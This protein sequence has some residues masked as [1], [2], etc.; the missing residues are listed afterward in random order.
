MKQN[1]L[2]SISRILLALVFI[3]FV[4]QKSVAQTVDG[5]INA[6]EYGNHTDGFNKQGNAYM[7]WDDTN[8]YVGI[9]GSN[10]GESAIIYI[11]KNPLPSIKGGTNADGTLVGQEYDGTNFSALPFRADFVSYFKSGYHEYRTADGSNG[12]SG[13][14]S[15][16][17]SFAASGDSRELSIPW[18][19]MG[20]KPAS[21]AF[22]VYVTSSGG[23]VYNQVP[24]ENASG[25][26]GTSASYSRY[27]IVDNTS[28]GYPFANNPVID[29]VGWTNLQYPQSVTVSK[30]SGAT[31]IFMQV[32]K[33]GVTNY[34]GKGAGIDVCLG[35]NDTDS[36][37]STW[38]EDKWKT[39]TYYKDAGNNDEYSAVVLGD[40]LD[41]GTYYYATRVRYMTNAYQYGGYNTGGGGFWDGATN[42]CGVLT[43]Q[44]YS[45][46]LFS[47]TAPALTSTPSFPTANDAITINFDASLGNILLKDL[48]GHVVYAHTG[49]TTPAGDWQ[50]S[51]TWLQNDAE[52]L[53]TW[54]SGNSYTLSIPNVFTYYGVS[55]T[56]DIRKLSFVMRNATGTLQAKTADN[57][58]F[59]I[60]LYADNQLHVRFNYPTTNLTV[61][62]ND[63][64][65]I[66]AESN[67]A[68]T[69]KL[70]VD[71][72]LANTVAALQMTYT[73]SCG[74]VIGTHEVKIVASKA[75]VSD[76]EETISYYVT[77]STV[78]EALPAGM[79]DGINYVDA[80]TVTLVLYAPQK[81]YIHAIGDFNNWEVDNNYL[82]KRTPDNL[83][84]WITL[85]GL[86]AG[87][88]YG[89]Q[90]LIDGNLRIADPYTDKILDPDNDKNISSSIYP[91]LKLYPTGKTEQI[92]S[93]FQTAK[94]PYAWEIP[95]FSA[96]AQNQLIIYELHIRDFTATGDINGVADKLD[97]LKTL[98]INAIE[99]MPINE[100]EGNDS[101]GYNPSFYFA[102]DK[103]YGTNQAYK[104]FID[105][106]HKKGI[107]VI[108]DIVLNHSF[109]QSPMV[110]MYFDKANDR[111]APE[112]PWFN[113]TA[114]NTL[115][116]WGSDFNH[117]RQ[118][119]K[120]FV[121]RVS[122]YWLTEF[123]I[124]GI[125]FDFTKGFTQTVG[126]GDAYDASRI[127]ILERMYDAIKAVKPNAYVILE[128]LAENSEEI[129][130]ANH[131]IMLWKNMEHAY[132]EALSG[133]NTSGN[134]D[135]SG[136][137]FKNKSF[138]YAN[139]VSYAESHDEE[140]NPYKA[141]TYGNQTQAPVY[142]VKDKATYVNRTAMLEAFNLF[143][144]GPRMLWQFEELAY[145]YSINYNGRVG[146]KPLRWD[147]FDDTDRQGL[148]TK[149]AR[150]I[151]YRKENPT[152]FDWK[153]DYAEDNSCKRIRF[154]DP[155]DGTIKAVV[156]GNFGVATASFE[157]GFGV[158][159][160][161]WFEAVSGTS[162]GPQTIGNA[163]SLAPGEFKV[164]IREDQTINY[165]L[166]PPIG[167]DR[168]IAIN[169]DSPR[170]FNPTDFKFYSVDGKA[171]SAIK[172]KSI[173]G[174][175]TFQYNNA[176]IS[177]DTEILD[178]TK[179]TFTP[180][181][182]ANGSGYASFT[183][184]LEDNTT[185]AP[186]LS[187]KTY[188]TRINV[189][190]VNDAPVITGQQSLFVDKNSPLT[191][192]LNDLTVT[193]PDNAYPV[194]FSLTV[195]D[196][197]NY[198]RVGNTITPALNYAGTLTVTVTVNDGTSDSNTFNVQVKVKQAQTVSFGATSATYG[199]IDFA[200]ATATSGLTVTLSVPVGNT[201]ATIVGNQIHIVGAGT[202]DVT[203]KQTGDNDFSAA[204]E[205]TQT[206][207]VNKAT[208]TITAG[209]QSVPGGTPVE[210]VTGLGSYTATGFVN[211]DN[212]LLVGP[213]TVSYT[214][215]YTT[216]TPEGTSG[217][218]ITPVVTGLIASNYSFI[219]APGTIT[220]IAPLAKKLTLKVY[221]EG[222]WNGTA[223]NM[224]KCQDWV[225]GSETLVD[226]FAGD[227]VDMLSVELHDATTYST[228]AYQLTGLE[229]HQDG[230][231]TSV[232][233]SYIEIPTAATGS[234]FITVKHRNH[235][236]TTSATAVSFSADVNYDFTDVSTKAYVDPAAIFTPMKTLNGKWMLY[237][238]NVNNS[239]ANP[240]I[241]QDDYMQIFDNYSDNTGIYGYLLND[242]NGDGLVDFLDYMLNYHNQDIY[243]SK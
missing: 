234:Y 12:W 180:A 185:P 48:S 181:L 239:G 60:P 35:I 224:N 129:E 70:Y 160:M 13:A 223:L 138:T 65:E 228:V 187:E 159:G 39:A 205:I 95:T 102:P 94:T 122:A 114:P 209:D 90:Y 128:N 47:S 55:N 29:Q 17:G 101:W 151:Q 226:K 69:L 216:T 21:F 153:I 169:E 40:D 137:Y 89:F 34:I 154:I 202:V 64:I 241:D 204:P 203:A 99:L 49:I 27:F 28:S 18:T 158:G 11:D 133:W 125:R 182:N 6:G 190:A 53:L 164:L 235:L 198:T 115:Y 188:T 197:S 192:S 218:T 62:P 85:T 9:T 130:L 152:I 150:M 171:L 229:L 166:H 20:G 44:D 38:T 4:E 82:M 75:G 230:R 196:G 126:T 72:V 116:S 193:D 238:G 117:E 86:E 221:L 222:L 61:R 168:S 100:F 88:E 220:I 194:D 30:K 108:S 233:L 112:N 111:P 98:G 132:S 79:N 175:G 227:V 54:N 92:V 243:F 207:T 77:T 8:L 24:T 80:N 210:T 144:P 110:R 211:G 43:I 170:S 231:V 113:V 74:T 183:Y 105:A 161:N 157:P 134:S 240:I 63:Q 31:T 14:I 121:D 36:D 146:R 162:Y 173:S 139:L 97:Y 22:F 184:Q 57:D 58:D 119:T 56:T 32:Y 163:W 143:M 145:D 200:P 7:K 2:K 148:Y 167:E 41:V 131:G 155:N 83:R 219:P 136:A 16:S 140:R 5:V 3:L 66:Q 191:I 165:T 45:G 212:W 107:A 37:P 177:V 23:Y 118:V 104:Q 50:S 52:H 213:G 176:G 76:V 206:I 179:L 178:L 51:T 10:I 172:I 96:P 33:S 46:T 1:L 215:T 84:Y 26:I 208:V 156:L 242:L 67:S 68:E 174:A 232:G 15:A 217:I 120:D 237:T 147:Y 91:D 141:I 71:G 214:T 87:R 225:A 103:A 93:V 78:T 189:A 199:D 124:D 25:L 142:D 195:A 81:Q 123:K 19:T 127:A 109:N 59:F 236:E 135:L 149:M 201:V 73:V 106:C 42:V 186:L